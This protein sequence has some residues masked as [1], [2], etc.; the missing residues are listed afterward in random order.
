MTEREFEVLFKAQFSKLATVAYGVLRDRDEARDVVQAVFL[1]LWNKKDALAIHTSIEAYMS[2]AT[3][4]ASLNRIE[5]Q[6]R[7]QL[8]DEFREGEQPVSDPAFDGSSKD[9]L[10]GMVRR[11]I[12]SLPTKCQMV[13]SL[14]RFS[15]MT[16]QEIAEDMEISVKAVEK[17]ITTALKTLRTRLAPIYKHFYL[18]IWI[19]AKYLFVG[20]GFFLITLS[21]NQNALL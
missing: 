17:H 14:S 16:N 15:G 10:Y 13:F 1:Q 2:R 19:F 12:D 21:N 20:V 9:E 4:N 18:A 8:K 3:V 7:L 11:E 6:K 5:K